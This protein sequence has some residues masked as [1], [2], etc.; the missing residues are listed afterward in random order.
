M[1]M[2]ESVAEMVSYASSKA[3]KVFVSH[4]LM[5][6]IEVNKSVKGDVASANSAID[7]ACSAAANCTVV[8]TPE[9]MIGKNGVEKAFSIEDGIHLNAQGYRLWKTEINNIVK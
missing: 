8:P 6:N 4:V 2:G 9:G 7:I 3:K 5:P 1:R